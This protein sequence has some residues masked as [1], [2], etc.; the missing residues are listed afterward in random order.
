M[1]HS[2]SNCENLRS[3]SKTQ[4]I[5]LYRPEEDYEYAGTSFQRVNGRRKGYFIIHPDFVSENR[6][7]AWKKWKT[8]KKYFGE[9]K[10]I[11]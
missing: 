7:M 2:D 8:N 5:H 10:S 11:L 3:K 9:S 4:S 6:K 1:S